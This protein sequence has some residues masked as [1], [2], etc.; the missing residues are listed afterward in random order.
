MD[1]AGVHG[2]PFG[3]PWPWFTLFAC[4]FAPAMPWQEETLAMGVG[5][6][7]DHA[8]DLCG[9]VGLQFVMGACVRRG[10]AKPNGSCML[11]GVSLCGGG[12][13]IL[14]LSGDV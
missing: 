10:L 7:L 3:L 9:G 8:R 1:T 4:F 13:A 5:A 12:L 6:V 14:D 11:Q 2:F